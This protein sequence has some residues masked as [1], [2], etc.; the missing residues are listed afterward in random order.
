LSDPAVLHQVLPNGLTLLLRETHLAPV[1]NLQIWA[2]VGSADERPGEEGLAHFHEHMLFK[3]TERRGVGEVAGDVESAGGRINA[4]TSFDITVY[5]A[6]LPSDALDTGLDV[7]VDAVRYSRFD[8]DEVRRE[9]EVVLEEIRRSDD[10]PLHVLGDAVFQAAYRVHP[11]RAPILGTPENVASFD[12]QRVT[13][14][15]KRWYT[16]ENLVVVAA[17]DFD[18]SNL[19]EQVEEAFDGAER[20]RAARSRALEPE[21]TEL[22][23]VVLERPFERAR[24]DLS[25]HSTR[26][27]E[28]D[29]T[30]LDLLSFVLGECESSRLVR[31]VKERDGLVDRI[32]SASYTPL[33]PGLFSVNIEADAGRA[34]EAISAAVREVERVRSEP[35]SADE[36]ERARAN[37]LASQHFER[38][39]VFG[40]ASKLASFHVFGGD[41]R[42][43]EEYLE[44][45]QSATAQDLLRVAREYL[46]PERLTVGVLVP[47]G[48]AASLSEQLIHNAVSLGVEQTRR[49]FETPR[50]LNGSGTQAGEGDLYS[51]RLPNGAELHVAPR[52][53]VPVVAIRAAL[54]GG[55]LADDEASAGLTNFLTAMW[56]RG[57]RA[58][59]AAGLARAVENLAADIEGFSGRSSLGLTLDVTSDK[60][61]PSLDLFSEVLLEPAFDPEEI[62]RERRETLAAIERREDRLAQQAF[63]L[64]SQT[65]FEHHP[66]RLPIL[67]TREAIEGIDHARVRAHHDRLVDPRRL[68]IGVSGDVDPDSIAEALAVRLAEL[69]SGTEEWEAAPLEDPPDDIRTATLHKDRAQ[70]HV[71]LGFRGLTVRDP[72]RHALEVIS[73]LLAGQG[74]R[75]FLELRDR[76]SLAYSVSSVNVEGVAPGFFTVYIATAPEKIDE[77]RTGILEQLERLLSEGPGELELEHTKRHLIGNFAIDQQRNAHHAAHIALDALYGLGP[78]SDRSYTEH[79][80]NVTREDVL[81]VAERVLRLDAYTLACVRP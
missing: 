63:M 30:Y 31:M 56:L 16:P 40:L 35:I 43:E 78:D 6:S 38:E 1:V 49:A 36:L 19:A 46:R 42:G 47:D 67:G 41:W 71:V 79:I 14:F 4:Y 61:L 69:P 75:L 73:Q 48:E 33:D 57:T 32:D 21:Q 62:E 2:Q 70:A 8:E 9:T 60:L 81:R 55:L 15:F 3:G 23:A 17:G 37:F 64:F 25:W 7:L 12:R 72:D 5:H 34:R 13:D 45:L 10:S 28:R 39:S 52:H 20:G 80:E 27:C 24:V 18:A 22:R 11:Y 26:Q 66:Y 29:A 58:R 74:G 68:V 54:P 51:Y 76:R 50:R 65:L 59:S 53:D 44:T 77:A